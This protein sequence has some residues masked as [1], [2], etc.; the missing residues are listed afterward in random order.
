MRLSENELISVIIPVYNVKSYLKEAL[1]SVLNQTYRN[2]EIIIVDDGSTDG[3]GRICDVYAQKDARIKVIHQENMG[4]SAARNAGLEIMR[5]ELVAFLDSDDAYCSNMICSMHTAMKKYGA[6][7]VCCKYGEYKT[8]AKMNPKEMSKFKINSYSAEGLY[9]NKE[10]L[11]AQTERKISNFAW[12]KLY[13]AELFRNIRYPVGKTY[14]DRAVILPLIEATRRVYVMNKYLVM[15]RKRPGSIT[16]TMTP[17]VVYDQMYVNKEYIQYIQKHIPEYFSEKHL[18][19]VMKDWYNRLLGFYFRLLNKGVT[20][21]ASVMRELSKEL[22]EYKGKLDH[23]DYDMKLRMLEFMYL[24]IPPYA[25]GKIFNHYTS[26]Q[27][28]YLNARDKILHKR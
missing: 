20:Q 11:V 15:Y 4:L 25:C 8:T 6:E 18:K 24:H 1:D 10:A 12:D 19:H 13:K 7:M 5:G 14:E 3:S 28:V 9:S 21:Q 23:N 16:V 2:L 17:R 27:N 22:N 26:F